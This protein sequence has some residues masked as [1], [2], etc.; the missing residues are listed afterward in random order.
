[1][2]VSFIPFVFPGVAHVRCAF[3]IRRQDAGDGPYAGGNISLAT[4]DDRQSV[5]GNRRELRAAL[6]LAR[7]AE[8]NQVHGDAMIFE[9]EAVEPDAVPRSDAD[10]MATAQAGLGLV[11]KTADCQ[12]ILLAHKSGRFVA[13]LHAGWRGNR[14]DFPGSGVRRFCEHYGVEPCELLAVR[15]PSLGPARAEFVN[16]ESEWGDGFRPWFDAQSRTMDLWGLTRWQLEQAGLLPRN[17]YG[18]DLCTASCGRRFFSYRCEKASGRQASVIWRL[19]QAQ[20][21]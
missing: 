18:I 16:F 7:M 9:P 17:I 15:G 20:D 2:P 10:G 21:S 11:I 19:D 5:I 13:A 8:L 1:M 4:A 12:P 14:C 3:Q 6:G